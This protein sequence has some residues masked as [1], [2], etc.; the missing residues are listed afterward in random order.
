MPLAAAGRSR[1]TAPAD[2]RPAS[3]GSAAATRC[4]ARAPAPRPGPCC[5]EVQPRTGK[6]RWRA[7][8]WAPRGCGPGPA[9]ARLPRRSGSEP[10]RRA[11]RR[12]GTGP[13]G[14]RRRSA[15]QARP[16]RAAPRPEPTRR[17]RRRCLRRAAR[18]RRARRL[19]QPAAAAADP[20]RARA[21]R[22]GRGAGHRADLRHAARPGHA[23]TRSWP[24]AATVT[25]ASST[26]RCCEVL[27]LGAHQL[28]GTRVA[29]HAAVA[30]LGR[31][32][33]G[34]RR[35]P[36]RPSSSTRCCAGWPP[37][38]WR[39]GWT[40]AAPDRADDL[41]GHLARPLQP[42]ALDRH[43]LRDGRS[44]RTPAGGLPETEARSRP[45]TSGPAV[46]LWRRA[47]PA[48]SPAELSTGRGRSPAAGRRI[49]ALPGRAATRRAIPA[50][51][52]GR[53]G[54]Q[55]EASQL[56]R[57]RADAARRLDGARR[58]RWLDLCAGP[59]G[60]ARLLAA[61][62]AA[63]RRPAGRRRAAAAPGPAGRAAALPGDRAAPGRVAD[64]TRP[65]WPAGALRPGARRRAV[66]R[67]R[68]AAPP[69]GGSLAPAAGRR[70]RL[71]PAAAR[72]AGARR[73]T[74]PGPAASSPT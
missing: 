70:R 56:A 2:G 63:A 64:G 23:T 20:D 27:R 42:P 39:P 51:P 21:D 26:R 43:R 58:R 9:S 33:P 52:Q 62:A 25:W 34:G 47:R 28:L 24:S 4:T 67:T 11:A 71:W 32:G 6:R 38:T 16:A 50:V 61:L 53:A 49:G 54:V 31:P 66:L 14:G 72:P 68:R 3:C 5:G 44:A 45:T 36:A 29:P 74:P 8:D 57:A 41:I 19:R 13:A 7:A 17:P 48:P 30:D 1:R 35:A 40:I 15:R 46:T 55:D 65:A 60:K 37:A 10:D 69:P 12:T 59:G 22:P 73:W 18:G